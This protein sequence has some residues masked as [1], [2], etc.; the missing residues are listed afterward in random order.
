M[1][2]RTHNGINA[3]GTCD[4]RDPCCQ[5]PLV[6]IDPHCAAARHARGQAGVYYAAAF[7]VKTWKNAQ[8]GVSLQ[9]I[10]GGRFKTSECVKVN[11]I[12]V[13]VLIKFY[14]RKSI[15]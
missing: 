5:W 2:N 1:R 13:Y 10:K 9:T 7:V 11:L 3:G 15:G 8:Y 12:V 6:T 14:K 4:S